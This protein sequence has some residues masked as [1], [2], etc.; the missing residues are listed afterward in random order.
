MHIV[1]TGASRGIGFELVKA[2]AKDNHII[3]AIARNPKK[4][5]ILQKECLKENPHAQVYPFTFDVGTID[6]RGP[7]L[8]QK[9]VETLPTVDILVNNAANLINKPF[10]SLQPHDFLETFSINFF[11]VVSLIQLLLPYM[12][13]EKGHIVNISSMGG[14]QGS[15]KFPGLTAYSCSKSALN[16]L[17]EMLAVEL[18][19]RNIRVNCLALGAVQTEMLAE[20][21]PDYKADMTAARMAAFIAHF[22]LTGH[23]YFNGKIIPVS[24][25]TP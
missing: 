8:I 2:F 3:A 10:E 14:V 7:E 20:A 22:A 18:K 24:F 15:S 12:G 6:E 17:T 4:L 21:F 25:S 1:V 11:G 9:L 13:K 23:H 19:A 16:C 5:E